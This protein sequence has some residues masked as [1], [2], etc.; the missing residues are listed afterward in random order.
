MSCAVSV[1]QAVPFQG[2]AQLWGLSN[3]ALPMGPAD[4]AGVKTAAGAVVGLK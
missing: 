4:P 1:A 3:R 2:V